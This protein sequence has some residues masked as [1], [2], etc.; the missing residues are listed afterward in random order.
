MFKYSID[1]K[2]VIT[3]QGNDILNLAQSIFKSKISNTYS[4]E[5][6]KVSEDYVMRPD[7]I[8][9]IS[10]GTDEYTEIILKINGII[11][12]FSIDK[13]DIIVIPNIDKIKN[14]LIDN[15][16]TKSDGD[17]MIRNAYKYIDKSKYPVNSSQNALLNSQTIGK[18]ILPA[19]IAPEN[20]SP[21]TN[22]NGR[23]YF[24]ENSG[25]KCAENGITSSEY[26]SAMVLNKNKTNN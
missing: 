12:P 6:Y 22:R 5:V 26:I 23:I 9:M 1:N 15:S 7:L 11:N 18:N 16:Q 10:Y 21:I 24:A 13:D 17:S 3:Y 14:I 25:I 20:A 4:Y 8:S 2:S 19:N